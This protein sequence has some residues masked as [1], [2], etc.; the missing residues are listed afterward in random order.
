MNRKLRLSLFAVSMLTS[1]IFICERLVG[2]AI[3]GGLDYSTLANPVNP[4]GSL[5]A[6]GLDNA[7]GASHFC[8]EYNC[9][10]TLRSITVT[11]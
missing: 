5:G 10:E 9:L 8:S 1:N 4:A 6:S 2:Q 3:A 7:S 11:L